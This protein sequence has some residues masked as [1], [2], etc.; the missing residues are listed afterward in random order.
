MRGFRVVFGK[1]FRESLRDRRSVTSAL[2]MG[3]LLGPAIFAAMMI[4]ILSM[5]QQRAEETLEVPVVGAEHAPNLVRWM[6]QQGTVIKEPPDDPESAV[7]DNDEPMVMVI[8]EGFGKRLENGEPAVVE[9][10]FDRSRRETD[11][12]VERLRNQVNTYGRTIGALRLQARGVNPNVTRAVVVKNRDIST[13][14]SRG[15]LVLGMMPYF[16]M[17]S[18]FMGGMYLAIDTTAGE[19][20]RQSLEPLLLNPVPRGE[21]MAGKLGATIVFALISLA[22]T[23]TAFAVA[24]DFVPVAELGLGLAL[25]VPTCLNLFLVTAPMTIVAGALQTIVAAFAKSFREAQTYLSFLLFVP[26]FPTLVLFVLPVKAKL[27]MMTIPILSQSLLIQQLV[28]AE[29]PEPGHVGVSVLTTLLAGA[30]LAGLA[31][32]L[33]HS[34]RL[35][36]SAS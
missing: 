17:F 13:P 1:E 24:M 26:M 21:I 18:V 8:P 6:E 28:R 35:A 10:V 32:R 11:T 19:R 30:A 16:L 33:Y 12:L 3:P 9:V 36:F 25:D 7:S 27:W 23:V 14:E 4:G 29:V 5:E 22:L 2:V 31:A 34:E 15:A 20:E